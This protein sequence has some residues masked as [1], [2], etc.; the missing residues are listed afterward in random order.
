MS[1]DAKYYQHR[2]RKNG[3]LYVTDETEEG[4][5]VIRVF[6]VVLKFS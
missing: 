5:P 6:M 4:E 3:R 2:L 1:F